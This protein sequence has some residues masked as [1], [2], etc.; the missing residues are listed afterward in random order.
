M[1]VDGGVAMAREVLGASGH[2]GLA[3]A[4]HERRSVPRKR[5]IVT[6][7]THTDHRVVRLLLT[8]TGARSSV[9]GLRHHRAHRRRHAFGQRD[10]VH[11]PAALPGYEL[12][13]SIS[14][15]VTS[16]PSSSV[17][18][19]GSPLTSRSWLVSRPVCSPSTMLSPKN[20]PAEAAL[21]PAEQPR[22]RRRYGTRPGGSRRW[23]RRGPC[24]PLTAPAVSPAV[25]RCC[26]MRKNTITGMA[27]SVEP[28]MPTPVRP[29]APSLKACSHTGRV[30]STGC[31]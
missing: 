31:R 13:V 2:A 21:Q 10:V 11:R 29:F 9:I 12:P 27:M 19:T 4:A 26:T 17:A 28:A 16:P 8:S 14:S 1:R 7:R 6:E 30:W 15:L 20:R 22:W 18:T 3:E 23:R 25:T 5:G 24:Q